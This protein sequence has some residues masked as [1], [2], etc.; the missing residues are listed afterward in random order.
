MLPQLGNQPFLTDGGLETV[1]LFHHDIDLPHF[2]SFP[3]LDDEK[4]LQILHDYYLDYID[5]ARKTGCGFILESP[6]WRASPDWAALLDYDEHALRDVNHKA[7][8]LLQSIKAENRDVEMVVSGCIGPRGDGYIAENLM[9]AEEAETFHSGQVRVFKAAG[10]ELI[11][12]IT[13]TYVEEALGIT[14]AA[15]ANGLPVVISFTVEL[16]GRLPS[17]LLLSD[18]IR[19]LDAA[20]NNGPSYYM[21]NCAHPEHFA[22]ILDVGSDWVQRIRGLRCNASKCSHAELDEALELDDGDP[23]ELGEQIAQ[24]Q[25]IHPQLTIMGGCCGTDHRHIAA[26]AQASS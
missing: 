20:T 7:I 25:K 13:M 18:A 12:A 24:L 8:T 16:D 15:Q 2:A 19:Q 22:N 21:I 10:S 9:S 11:T 23:Q 5:I 14:K 6:T 4:G 17:G 3:L 26:I 1:L